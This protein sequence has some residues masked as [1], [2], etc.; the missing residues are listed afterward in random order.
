MKYLMELVRVAE[1]KGGC[2]TSEEG[3][4]EKKEPVKE[5]IKM[6]SQQ[7]LPGCVIACKAFLLNHEVKS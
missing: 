7:Y 4:S 3:T 5:E 2:C 6:W 1:K